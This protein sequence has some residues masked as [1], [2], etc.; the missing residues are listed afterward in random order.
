MISLTTT[1]IEID[2][3]LLN[4]CLVLAIDEGREQTQA[5]HALQRQ[6][7]TLAGLHAR[8]EREQIIK[9]HRTHSACWSLWPW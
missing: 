7:R 3:E 2:E 5:I 9:L 8:V 1:A 6:R 4:R